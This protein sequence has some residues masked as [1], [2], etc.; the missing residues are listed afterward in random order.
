MAIT[1]DVKG[2]KLVL[3]LAKGS[4]TVSN[5]S[6]SATDEALYALGQAVGTL[7]NEEV[8]SVSKVIETALISE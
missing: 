4:Q 2:V 8:E 6:Q 1:T 3:K 5:C 7:Q